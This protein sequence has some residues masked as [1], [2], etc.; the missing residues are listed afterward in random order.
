MITAF[1]FRQRNQIDL[2]IL[3]RNAMRKSTLSSAVPLC[4]V[5]TLVWTESCV[6]A[7]IYLLF[8][9]VLNQMSVWKIS[10]NAGS[11]FSLFFVFV[12]FL[13]Q[14]K[15]KLKTKRLQMYIKKTGNVNLSSAVSKTLICNVS[16]SS[17]WIRNLS[18]RSVIFIETLLCFANVLAIFIAAFTRPANN[19]TWQ[20]CLVIEDVSVTSEAD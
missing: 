8:L 14:K 19:L 4:F 2:F 1:C 10:C 9:N 11:L 7:T 13:L 20:S 6:F 15:K 5:S 12:C 17:F 18:D 16:Q 3:E